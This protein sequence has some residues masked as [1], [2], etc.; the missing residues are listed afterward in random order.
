MS[1]TVSHLIRGGVVKAPV[2]RSLADIARELDIDDRHLYI[3]V[4]Q[5][6]RMIGDRYVEHLHLQARRQENERL[7][8]LRSAARQ[9]LEE[10]EYVSV[11]AVT[12]LLGK[13]QVNSI[14]S[15]YSTLSHINA[16]LDAA[17]ENF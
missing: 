17:N 10:G 15:L 2:V 8:E 3:Q 14:R 4:T 9:I 11:A 7:N 6:A 13:S 12:Q 16:E 5:E 1:L